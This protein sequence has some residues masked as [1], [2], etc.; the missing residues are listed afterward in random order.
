MP[1]RRRCATR[2]GTGE[3]SRGVRLTGGSGKLGSRT[4]V[5]LLLSLAVLRLGLGV[6]PGY[7]PDLEMFKRWS[8]WGAVN[9]IHTIYDEG[10]QY[11]YPP[12]YGFML[13]PAG[14]IEAKLSPSTM[15][16]ICATLE[17]ASNRFTF[18]W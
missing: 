3:T 14:A 15:Y 5:A 17:Y 18:C 1:R 16:P 9:G 6:L 10:S 2:T 13:A 11:D 12:L 8:V 7:P 4:L